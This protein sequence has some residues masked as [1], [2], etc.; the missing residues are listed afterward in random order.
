MRFNGR[1][2]KQLPRIQ[3]MSDF[4]KNPGPANGAATNHKAVYPI[5]IEVQARF[6]GRSNISVSNYG[7]VHAWIIFYRPDQIPVGLP[8]V[9]LR[10]GTTV[11]G[12]GLNAHIL[13]LLGQGTYNFAV[14]V[15]SQTCFY[16][17]RQLYR[18]HDFFGDL[19]QA[20]HIA[21]HTRTGSLHGNLFYG[22][23]KI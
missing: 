20:G 23:A 13:Q 21:Q 14:L 8:R 15:P 11:N 10:T 1:W 19:Q 12:Q 6:F 18:L 7:N 5:T 9:H 22:T 16:T 2:W 3:K 17:H 4:T